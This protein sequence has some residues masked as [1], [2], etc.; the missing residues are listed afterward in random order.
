M[1]VPM[2]ASFVAGILVGYYVLSLADKPSREKQ[3]ES[4][5][6][7]WLGKYNEVRA[8]NERLQW[9]LDYAHRNLHLDT[10]YLATR[11]EA[12]DEPEDPREPGYWDKRGNP[13]GWPFR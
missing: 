13:E 9:M 8:E 1:I 7:A 2:L 5:L 6:D 10:Q 4:D 3:A 11:W 12:K